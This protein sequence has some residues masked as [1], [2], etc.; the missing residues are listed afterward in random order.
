MERKLYIGLPCYNEE[1]DIETLLNRILTLKAII[2]N[3]YNVEMS[4]ICV[5]DGSTDKTQDIIKNR[6]KDGVDLIN[7]DTNKGLGEAMRT[8]LNEFV[9]KGNN[10]DFLIVMDSDNSHN[11]NYIIDLMQKQIKHK[12]DIVI[13]SRYQKG[14]N[15]VGLKRYRILLSDCARIWYTQMLKIPNTTDYTCGYR[16]YTYD[17]VKNTYKKY[18]ES[19]ITQCGFACMMEILYKMHLSGA[20]VEEV[21]FLLEYNRKKGKSKMKIVKTSINSL[22]TTIRIRNSGGSNK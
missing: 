16:L 18:S 4:I 8:I 13:A 11:P 21:P 14:S 6:M 10:N 19:I 15:I 3:D 7:H 17:V 22:I 5:N 2:K 9:H 12:C 1:A 20:K